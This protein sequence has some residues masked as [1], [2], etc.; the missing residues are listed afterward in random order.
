MKNKYSGSID[1]YEK[2]LARVMDR[3]GVD[4]D[5]YNYDFNSTRFDASCFVEM[6][7]KG[8]TYRFENS[9][10]KSEQCGKNLKSTTDLLASIVLTLE[11]MA[12][13][14][15][16]GILTLDIL[17]TGLPALPAA[18]TLPGWAVALGFTAM[19]ETA[20]EVHAQYAARLKEVHPDTNGAG[21]LTGSI[22]ALQ[23]ARDEG[24]KYFLT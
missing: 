1:F 3:F 4:E 24:V 13:A 19:P 11:A 7:Y 14:T 16:Q 20:A 21:V 8:K 18:R 12:R 15:E 5:H 17:L 23:S 9:R 22:S 2:K 10:S 6:T